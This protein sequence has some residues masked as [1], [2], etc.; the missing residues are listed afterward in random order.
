VRITFVI[1]R[2]G[3]EVVGG[4][5]S[6]TRDLSVGLAAEGHK[7]D[8]VTS[9]ATSYAD[10]ADVYPPGASSEDG[11][12]VYRLPVVAPR[13]NERF[14]PLHLRIVDTHRVPMWPWAQDRWSSMMGPELQGGEDVVRALARDADVVVV[15]GYHYAQS[16]RLTRAA[17][18]VAPTV[19]IPTAH[20]EGA[21]HTGRVR[22]MFE[23]ADRVICLAAEEADLVRRVAHPR[24]MIDVV[25]C[26]VGVPDRPGPDRIH[27]VR[28]RFGLGGDPYLISIGRIDPAKG[29]DDAVRSFVRSGALPGLRLVLVGP[30]DL[31]VH[32]PGVVV[33]GFVDESDKLALLAGST[34]LLQPSYMES[35]SLA[36]IEGWLLRRPALVQGRNAVLAGHARRSGGGLTYH[37]LP[38]FE[39][40]TV[41]L[42]EDRD[43]CARLGEAGFR[44]SRRNFAWEPVADRFLAAVASTISAGRARL[45]RL[46]GDG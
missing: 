6:F 35:F 20:P 8:V 16:L 28:T 42:V 44:Y 3:V 7:V 30:G 41:A 22:Q 2:Y 36:L 38:S 21:F 5:E 31:G 34:V 32:E 33:T 40:A 15:V 12:S 17:A 4:A 24:C 37:D 25:G 1:Q 46:T 23:Y 13:D 45:G 14:I 9:C 18:A 29:S 10:W 11:V 43:L 19:V 27:E 39:A 26:P